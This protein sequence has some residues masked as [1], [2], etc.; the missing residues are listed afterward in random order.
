MGLRQFSA[1]V[2]VAALATVAGSVACR[3][4]GQPTP[5]AG[6]DGATAATPGTPG[7]TQPA[8]GGAGAT[9]A[10]VAEPE[11]DWSGL[12][13]DE[14]AR[15]SGISVEECRLALAE[16]D[17][18]RISVC[19]FIREV[20]SMPPRFRSGFDSMERRK[21]LLEDMISLAVMEQEARRLGLD[22]DPETQFT[23][24]HPGGT[25]WRPSSRAS[26]GCRSET[27]AADER[28]TSSS[29]GTAQPSELASAA[30]SWWRRGRKRRS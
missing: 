23:R 24:A 19:D 22:K 2:F 30:P 1:M 20:N 16:G 14:V 26:C 12:T 4:S 25:R 3:K 27:I 21:E 15:R 8:G 17:G 11:P 13:D 10:P 7:G 18:F 29:T 9:P 28:R 5:R 6:A